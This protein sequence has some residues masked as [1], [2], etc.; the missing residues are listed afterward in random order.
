MENKTLIRIAKFE[1]QCSN[2]G[3]V[4][5]EMTALLTRYDTKDASVA[6]D[7]IYDYLADKYD[8]RHWLVIVYDV[9]NPPE[10]KQLDPAFHS[11]AVAKKSAQAV[12]FNT[13]DA[14]V[15][16]SEDDQR[17]LGVAI[18][19][20][21]QEATPILTVN[22]RVTFNWLNPFFWFAGWYI[23]HYKSFKIHFY[24]RIFYGIWIFID[25]FIHLY[26]KHLVSLSLMMIFFRLPEILI[27]EKFKL[28][29][30]S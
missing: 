3:R 25:H 11:A 18:E 24:R 21:C 9:P 14:A 6:A 29:F 22:S 26:L 23:S 4:G 5:A 15:T 8:T 12:S 16:S 13:T 1:E 27:L 20:Y 28:T 17:R 10:Q 2:E 7:H 19:T 30:L